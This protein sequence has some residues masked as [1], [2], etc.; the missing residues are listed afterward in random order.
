MRTN[1]KQKAR[2]D[3]GLYSFEFRMSGYATICDAWFII[4][5]A[6]GTN[7]AAAAIRL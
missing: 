1:Q 4:D 7:N 6:N 2:S 5:I 3:P